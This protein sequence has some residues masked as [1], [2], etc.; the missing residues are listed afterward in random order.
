VSCSSE[1][2]KLMYPQPSIQSCF[3]AVSENGISSFVEPNFL[4]YQIEHEPLAQ[5]LAVFKRKLSF[6]I[7]EQA[8][9][10]EVTD[11]RRRRVQLQ[12]EG[13]KKSVSWCIILSDDAVR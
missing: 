5:E 4:V 2:T 11:Q 3:S 6:G 13:V 7:A 12:E 9:T 1:C 8:L 10:Q